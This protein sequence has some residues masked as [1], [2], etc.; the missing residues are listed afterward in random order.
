MLRVA[1]G[2]GASSG[3]PTFRRSPKTAQN[4]GNFPERVQNVDGLLSGGQGGH[5]GWRA[6]ANIGMLCPVKDALWAPFHA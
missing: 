4:E 1:G 3:T 2:E 5:F 6:P